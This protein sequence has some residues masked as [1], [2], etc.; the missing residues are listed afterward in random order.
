MANW[1]NKFWNFGVAEDKVHQP[2]CPQQ[3]RSDCGAYVMFFAARITKSL[4]AAQE[5]VFKAN[6]AKF[7]AHAA[8]KI[9]HHPFSKHMGTLRDTDRSPNV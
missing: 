4:T 1:L 2:T 5:K 8:S 3:R 7:R 9:V 6:I